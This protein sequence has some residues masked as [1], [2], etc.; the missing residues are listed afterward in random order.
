MFLNAVYR[1]NEPSFWVQTLELCDFLFY[2]MFLLFSHTSR[3][4]SLLLY[5]LSTF[6]GYN[7]Y[8]HIYEDLGTTFYVRSTTKYAK[9]FTR[10]LFKKWKECCS[11]PWWHPLKSLNVQILKWLTKHLENFFVVFLSFCSERSNWYRNWYEYLLS[12]LTNNWDLYKYLWC[13]LQY[14]WVKVSFMNISGYKT[15]SILQYIH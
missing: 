4:P 15:T 11:F 8:V 9:D 12:Y 1:R 10:F 5:T 3:I 6:H 13:Y 14:F 2:R 7:I